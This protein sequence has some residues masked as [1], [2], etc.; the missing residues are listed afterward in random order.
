MFDLKT[1]LENLKRYIKVAPESAGVYRMISINDEVLYVG[2]SETDMITADNLKV[3][4][5][6]V[7]YGYR[8]IS[9]LKQYNPDYIINNFEELISI[10]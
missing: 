6:A 9:I 4:K 5:I 3:K 1:G 8:D 10:I 2:D 7:T